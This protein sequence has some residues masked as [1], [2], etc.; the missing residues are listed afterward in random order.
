MSREHQEAEP[1]R[2]RLTPPDLDFHVD[3]EIHER[4]GRL[5][6]LADLGEESR[7]SA[8]ARR[9]RTRYGPCWR[10]WA[11]RT[12]PRWRATPTLEGT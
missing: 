12:R 3:V 2:L 7:E 10:R 9:R 5:L 4:D 8:P 11:S 6:A 1:R